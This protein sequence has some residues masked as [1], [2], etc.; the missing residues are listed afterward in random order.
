M[1]PDNPL[2]ILVVMIS[3]AMSKQG[4]FSVLAKCA[5]E[6][7]TPVT[8]GPTDEEVNICEWDDVHVM[9]KVPYA[10]MAYAIGV[11]E[12]EGR[13]NTYVQEGDI[14]T[15]VAFQITIDEKDSHLYKYIPKEYRED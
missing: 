2:T 3:H 4:K 6:L 8:S 1:E 7:S 12:I 5:G 10:A 14:L 15:G 11:C 13:T 9:E